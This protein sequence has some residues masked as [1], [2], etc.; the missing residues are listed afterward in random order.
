MSHMQATVSSSVVN[1]GS[2]I[3]RADLSD[4]QVID[5]V[6][7][8]LSTGGRDPAAAE[9]IVESARMGEAG[10]TSVMRTIAVSAPVAKLTM[11]TQRLT[12]GGRNRFGLALG[13]LS[14]MVRG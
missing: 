9:A 4:D 14:S 11:P 12:R 5:A 6:R 10:A 8:R 13:R 7:A 3:G 1:S 2:L